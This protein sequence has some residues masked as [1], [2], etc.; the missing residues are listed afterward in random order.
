MCI[1][2]S[3]VLTG[4]SFLHSFAYTV[5]PVSSPLTEP[6]PS[7]SNNRLVFYFVGHYTTGDSLND[8]GFYL[9]EFEFVFPSTPSTLEIRAPNYNDFNIKSNVLPSSMIRTAYFLESGNLSSSNPFNHV[10]QSSGV[11]TCYLANG[12]FPRNT[13]DYGYFIAPAN[14]TLYNPL[15]RFDEAPFVTWSQKPPEHNVFHSHLSEPVSDKYN[16]YFILDDKLYWI[17]LR[18]NGFY[19][20]NTDITGHAEAFTESEFVPQP[21]GYDNGYQQVLVPYTTWIADHQEYHSYFDQLPFSLILIPDPDQW[22]IAF[23]SSDIFSDLATRIDC[24]F[25]ISEFNLADGTYITSSFTSF[26]RDNL[27]NAQYALFESG[28]FSSIK[29]YGIDF[30]NSLNLPINLSDVIFEYDLEFEQWKT[31]VL[32]YLQQIYNLLAGTETPP[33]DQENTYPDFGGSLNEAESGY[34]DI[35][36]ENVALE[37][38]GALGAGSYDSAASQVRD[39]INLFSIPKI[40]SVCV[41]ALALGTVTLTLGK[42]KSD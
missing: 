19:V 42:K 12:N 37:L 39:W 6:V 33:P 32:S 31:D 30:F 2:V 26:Q 21:G 25:F 34:S 15:S 28:S 22:K 13:C 16:R 1:T 27:S 23:K 20:E 24:D 35:T 10:S 14:V 4:L 36:P 38:H 5:Q 7:F 8:P 41:L 18:L 29:C 40:I 9:F 3:V 11:Y 17:S